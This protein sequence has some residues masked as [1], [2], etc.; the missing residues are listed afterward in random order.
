MK[1]DALGIVK[2]KREQAAAKGVE[3]S[4]IPSA[5]LD[6]SMGGDAMDASETLPGKRDLGRRRGDGVGRTQAIGGEAIPVG[7]SPPG[8]CEG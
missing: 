5:P 4:D 3:V 8:L 7:R 6:T 2:G 1:R